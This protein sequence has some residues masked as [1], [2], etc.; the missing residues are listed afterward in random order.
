MGEMNLAKDPVGQDK[1]ALP[2]AEAAHA[3]EV[4]NEGHT[5]DSDR[6]DG[7]Y[8]VHP[9]TVVRDVSE[10][11]GNTPAVARS[12]YIDPRVVERF[13]ADWARACGT[14]HC[15]GVASGT[16]ALAILLQAA[17]IGAGDEVI[18][19]DPEWP[20]TVIHECAVR[21]IVSDEA[22]ATP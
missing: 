18:V 21:E 7:W 9:I 12:A 22:A 11:L 20:A 16:A 6:G 15:V 10:H 4:H 3:V 2:V 5:A 13:E 8:F 14:R 1:G 17:G 19:P